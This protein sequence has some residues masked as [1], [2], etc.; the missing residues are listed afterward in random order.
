VP[1]WDAFVRIAHWTLVLCVIAAWFARGAPHEWLGYAALAVVVLRIV[2]GFV[3]ARHAR[4]AHFV[5]GPIPTLAYAR[6]VVGRKEERHLGHNPL[7]G[8]MIVALLVMLLLIS[9]SGWLASTDRY[10]GIAWV[11]DLHEA[12][13]DALVVLALLHVGGVVYSSLRHRENLVGAMVTGRKRP[14]AAGDVFE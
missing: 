11:Q 5:R 7:G 2:W 10:W 14:P 12:L 8:W 6:R 13:A 4:F 3:G 9:A 1:V